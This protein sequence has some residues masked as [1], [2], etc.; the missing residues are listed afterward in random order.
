MTGKGFSIARKKI[1]N[2]LMDNGNK[3][4]SS[5]ELMRSTYE[6]TNSRRCNL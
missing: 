1:L 6:Q 2:V 3:P 4:V 5:P